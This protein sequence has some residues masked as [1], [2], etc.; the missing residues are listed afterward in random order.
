MA[1]IYDHRSNRNTIPL[2]CRVASQVVLQE[3]RYHH[4]QNCFGYVE[5]S[6]FLDLQ[7]GSDRCH[8][9]ARYPENK[10]TMFPKLIII[11][12]WCVS[13]NLPPVGCWVYDL[14]DTSGYNI[15][16][17]MATKCWSFTA[18]LLVHGYFHGCWL[19]TGGWR[20]KGHQDNPQGP[21][22]NRWYNALQSQHWLYKWWINPAAMDNFQEF[23]QGWFKAAVQLRVESD[24]LLLVLP[25]LVL[26]LS[27]FPYFFCFLLWGFPIFLSLFLN[28]LY[29]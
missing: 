20:F 4:L 26:V 15:I 27:A 3:A 24:C 10:I 29:S 25:F 8:V 2:P 18:S 28:F 6:S 1:S 11:F 9:M 21:Q 22:G 13:L 7:S 12:T 23:Y 16:G 14:H 19:Q 5:E 17:I